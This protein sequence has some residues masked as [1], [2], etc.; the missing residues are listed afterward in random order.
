MFVDN[1]TLP[2]SLLRDFLFVRVFA[3]LSI[4]D[5]FVNTAKMGS[6][7]GGKRFVLPRM[8]VL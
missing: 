3:V 6:C 7:C 1:S 5:F 8:L 4:P 2:F